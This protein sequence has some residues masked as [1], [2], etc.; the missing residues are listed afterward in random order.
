VK[1]L[2]VAFLIVSVALVSFTAEY[3]DVPINH[4][5]YDAVQRVSDI[6]ILEGYPDGTFKGMEN[7]NRYQLTL[8]VSRTID[9][10]EETM[11][12][13][14]AEEISTLESK[15]S[16]INTTQSSASTSQINNLAELINSMDSRVNNLEGKVNELESSYELLGYTTTKI[17]DLE[18]KINSMNSSSISQDTISNLSSRVSRLENDLNNLM[19]NV[20]S[21]GSNNDN[22]SDRLNSV[23]SQVENNA[24][25]INRINT[26]LANLNSKI[27]MKTDSM[28]LSEMENKIS[29]IEDYFEVIDQNRRDISNLESQV[30]TTENSVS[31]LSK[32][33]ES[34]KNAISQVSEE[35]GVDIVD[36]LISIALSAGVSFA[37][38]SFM[39]N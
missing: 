21:M 18:R 12:S 29:N 13:P 24:N 34:N 9:Y 26:L 8:T 5:A 36:I 4:W 10:V 27:D 25:E 19:E 30:S 35:G 7:V 37:I 23:S 6:G 33:V 31:E 39:G 1:K 11:I 28:T 16:S 22:L 15:L 17:D 20:N 38:F 14:L 2:L 3:K 32:Q